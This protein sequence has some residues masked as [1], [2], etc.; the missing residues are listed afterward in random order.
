MLQCSREQDLLSH[1]ADLLHQLGAAPRPRVHDDRGRRH[2]PLPSAGRRPRVA[3]HRHRRAR[4]Q[5]RAGRGQGRC[6]TAGARRSELGGVSRRLA[7]PGHHPGR[8]HPHH[9]GPAPHRGAGHSAEAVGCRRDLPRQVRRPL[10]LRL[11]AVLHREG[12]RRRQVSGPPDAADVHRG[13][14]LLLQDVEVPGLAD[15]LHHRAARSDPARA[16]SQRDPRLP[17]GPAAGPVDQPAQA[18]AHVGDPAAV[19]RPV[20]DVRLVRRADQLLL[21]TRL[22]RRRAVS[23][24]LAGG[25]ARDRQ[26]HPEAARG[27]LA[28]HAEGG[29]ARHLSAPQRARVLDAGRRQDVEVDRQR[30]G[31]V[32]ALRQVRGRRLPL[33]RDARD[34]VRPRRG[35][36]RGGVRGP[37]QRRP[38]QRP[39]QSG[40][41]RH[42]PDRE[43]PARGRPAG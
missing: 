25:A 15:R 32:R 27:V 30:G 31:G 28:V 29:R 36:L 7:A 21:G 9:R 16:V 35:F 14:E 22:A 37:A 42:H 4:R 18:P 40:R 11:R 26:G 8:L 6:V 12:D 10:L 38:G 1:D 24:V 5:D 3:A 13:R 17:A 33:L 39:R 20:R 34:D 19:R 2:G 23:H 43:L 41:A